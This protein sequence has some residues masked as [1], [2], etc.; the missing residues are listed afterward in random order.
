VGIGCGHN[1]IQFVGYPFGRN[2][3]YQRV[4][5]SHEGKGCSLNEKIK[6]SGKPKDPQ[7]TKRVA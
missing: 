7:Q 3:R 4:M 6:G 1:T 5:A 2:V